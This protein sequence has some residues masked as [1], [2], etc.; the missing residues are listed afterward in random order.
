M[1]SGDLV[2]VE[3]LINSNNPLLKA[4]KEKEKRAPKIPRYQQ[5]CYRENRICNDKLIL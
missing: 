3:G 4:K 2:S 1:S 5:Y